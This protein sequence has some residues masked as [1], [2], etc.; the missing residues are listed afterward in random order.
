MIRAEGP[1]RWMVFLYETKW[2]RKF[3]KREVVVTRDEL[4]A[5][6]ALSVSPSIGK[7]TCDMNGVCDGKELRVSVI[8][9]AHHKLQDGGGKSGALYSAMGFGA[10]TGRDHLQHFDHSYTPAEV[11]QRLHRG[12][13]VTVATGK[14]DRLFSS[15]D[16]LPENHMLMVKDVH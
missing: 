7:G 8:E 2:G 10:L 16:L 6:C 3:E 11:K 13:A 15:R 5:S 12:E 9:T 4:P 14:W 1:D